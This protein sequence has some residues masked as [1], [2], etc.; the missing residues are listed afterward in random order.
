VIVK[1]QTALA[2]LGGSAMLLYD[3]NRSVL[4]E[5]D[6]TPE[7]L[8]LLAGRVKAYFFATLTPCGRLDLGVEAPRQ[9]GW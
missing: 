4:I 6:A 7:V 3:R 8:A 9:H 5:Q 2:P 1:V